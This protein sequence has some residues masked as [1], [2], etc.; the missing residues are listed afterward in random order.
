MGIYVFELIERFLN[1]TLKLDVIIHH[2]LSILMLI[3]NINNFDD[4][5]LG[6]HA[7]INGNNI[8][9][10]GDIFIRLAN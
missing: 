10:I 4:E 9:S 8:H 5:F 2:I 6:V 7:A 1:N 3:F